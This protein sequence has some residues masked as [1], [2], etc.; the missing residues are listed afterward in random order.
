V[1]A[2]GSTARGILLMIGAMVVFSAQD[3]I[4]KQLAANHPV[5]F[6]AMIRYWFFAAFVVALSARRP[7]GLRAVAQTRLP[8][9]Q[10]GRGALL[11]LEIWV[12]VTAFD[13]LGLAP[14]HAIFA[15]YSLMVVAMSGPLLGERIGWRRW[16]AV[17][18][19]FVGVLII[20][21]PGAAVFD[22]KALIALLAAAMF[23]LYNVATRYANR[24]DGSATSFFYTGVAGAVTVTLIGPF[25][26]SVPQGWDLVL[27]AVLCVS[28]VLGHYLLISALDQAEASRLQ[29]FSYLQL[30]FASALGVML[31]GETLDT[32]TIAGAALIVAAGLFALWRER[33]A[34]R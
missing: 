5:I 31:F 7:G 12:T 2:P 26:W 9:I 32:A 18:V 8:L 25:F 10:C 17:G 27:L 21:R 1:N 14:T 34:A 30:V 16:T 4:S 28:G 19:G 15:V 3:A 22:P 13:V 20:L 23:A 24:V 33:L 6:V 11:A 29:P